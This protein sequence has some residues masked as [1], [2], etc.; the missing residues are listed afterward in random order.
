MAAGLRGLAPP[1]EERRAEG[2]REVVQ[3]RGGDAHPGPYLPPPQRCIEGG[4]IEVK[5]ALDAAY[6]RF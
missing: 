1:R 6:Q 3:Q 4:K 5:S 2:D